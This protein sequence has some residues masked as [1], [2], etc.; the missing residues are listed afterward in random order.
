MSQVNLAEKVHRA[1]QECGE[2]LTAAEVLSLLAL[3]A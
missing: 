1:R 3:L 2:Q